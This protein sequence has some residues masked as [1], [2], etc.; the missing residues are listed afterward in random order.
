MD[1]KKIIS[2]SIDIQMSRY[3]I[4]RKQVSEI[5]YFTH[6]II[7]HVSFSGTNSVSVHSPWGRKMWR[8][9]WV[10]KAFDIIFVISR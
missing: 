9:L 2:Q 1:F 6:K 7:F 5:Y 10:L 3:K 4:F 8:S